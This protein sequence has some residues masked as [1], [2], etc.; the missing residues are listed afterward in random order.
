MKSCF[1]KIR[2]LKIPVKR[3]GFLHYI[4]L[5]YANLPKEFKELITNTIDEVC[6]S[7]QDRKMMREY[8]FTEK[9]L[10]K[11]AIDNYSSERKIYRLRTRVFSRL[12]KKIYIDG[13]FQ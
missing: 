4:C 10:I 6:K 5:G 1:K 2:S 12:Y 11:T 13:V 8:L 9:S 3:Q 7:E